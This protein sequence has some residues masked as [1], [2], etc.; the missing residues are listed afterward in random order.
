MNSGRVTFEH[1][2]RLKQ[3][4]T[5]VSWENTTRLCVHHT[6]IHTHT[7]Y[8]FFFKFFFYSLGLLCSVECCEGHFWVRGESHKRCLCQSTLRCAR[9]QTP[10]LPLS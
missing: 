7:I 5:C 8:I 6:H 10:G 2:A 4:L 9:R 1:K 3:I